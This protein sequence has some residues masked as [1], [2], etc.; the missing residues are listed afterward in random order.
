MDWVCNDAWRGPFTQTVFFLGSFI[1]CLS[2]GFTSDHLGRYK[3]FFITNVIVMV[4]GLTLPYCNT[5]TTFT[6]TRFVMGLTFNTFFTSMYILGEREK[7]L[8]PRGCQLG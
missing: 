6:V 3:T 4:S 5:F 7:P 2:F 8:L 1:G